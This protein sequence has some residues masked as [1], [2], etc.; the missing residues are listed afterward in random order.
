MAQRKAMITG[1]EGFVGP[2]LRKELEKHDYEVIGIDLSGNPDFKCDITDRKSLE[3]IILLNKPCHI[4]HLAGFSS[5]SQSFK[6]PEFCFKINV[7]G[8]RNLLESA[9][10][11]NNRRVLIVS[12]AEVYGN[13]KYLPVDENHPLAPLSPYGFS[14]VE[15]EKLALGYPNT[16]IA[17]SFNH[18]GPGQN[19]DFVIPSFIQQVDNTEDGG[20]IHVGNLE[21]IRDF[22]D[23][24]DV[25]RAYRLLLEK[26]NLG[27]IY[28]IGSGIG[29]KLGEVLKRLIKKS[30]KN[31]TVK[32]DPEKY[33]KV[34]IYELVCDNT[35][36]KKLGAKFRKI[37]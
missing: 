7:E 6:Q 22:S 35:K 2:Y 10:K 21:V 12:S 32:I 3:R 16:I 26:G 17:R 37:F 8:T 27:E 24:Q 5:P 14:R 13:P 31:I 11:L 18:T 36:I 9:S 34:D 4:F 20:T 15:Q 23:V 33:R 1:S 30:G 28:N 29:Y 25:V 19:S